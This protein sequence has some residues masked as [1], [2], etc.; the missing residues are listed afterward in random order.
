MKRTKLLGIKPCG[1]PENARDRMEV[2][3]TGRIVEVDGEKA[4]E[5]SMFYKGELKA[6]YFADEKVHYAYVGGK[7]NTCTLDN[8]ERLCKG[9]DVK[10]DAYWNVGGWKWASRE[11]EERAENFL[12]VWN[13]GAYERMLG[14]EKR[15][16]ARDRK[17]K[18]IE[19]EMA[20][21]PCVPDEV[22][23]WLES[24]IFPEHF[25]FFE[26]DGKRTTYNCTSCGCTGWKKI[27]WKRG[28]RTK[29]PKC[30]CEVRTNGRWAERTRTE[31]VVILQQYGQQWVE[32]QFKAVCKWGDGKKKINLYEKCRA[33]MEVG[34]CWGKVWY[35]L[36]SEADELEQDFWDANSRGQRF[37]NSYLWP[38]NLGEVLKCGNLEKSGMDILAD[39]GVKFNVNQF[40]TGFHNRPFVE[41]LIKTGLVRLAAEIVNDWAIGG[42]YVHGC[43]RTDAHDLRGTLQLDGNRVSRMKRMNG[44]ISALRW[45]QYE[46]KEGVRITQE[47]LDY[48]GS[49]DIDPEG[50]EEI[51]KG[52]KSVNRMVN[53]MKKQKVA[54]SKLIETWRDYLRMAEAEG[55]DVTDDIVRFPKD[56]KARHDQLVEIRNRRRDAERARKEEEK[57]AGLDQRIKKRLP[58]VA[59]Y[60][61][62]NDDYVVV[63]AARCKELVEEG[64]RLHHCV[65]ASDIY[66]ERMAEGKTW[67]L[68]LR[69]NV[70]L[71][72]PYYTIEID[73]KNDKI[74]QWYSE[75]DRKPDKEVVEKVL[76]KFSKSVKL[77]RKEEQAQAG[78]ERAR[79]QVPMAAMA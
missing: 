21:V 1:V 39:K 20:K 36:Y 9:E 52:L 79:V 63:P 48:L 68:F 37:T 54:T 56:L 67:I 53:Y 13:I 5:I 40:I 58:Q 19:E 22:G 50:C 74:L 32:R 75:Y 6:R 34:E 25:L 44:G 41:Y 70:E 60:Y 12:G 8:V 16:R 10:H 35:G 72:T 62:Q 14:G 69:K 38:G 47:S 29:C 42:H 55:M 33:V 15:E 26:K 76:K 57:Y 45:L 43:V 30:G 66:M 17:Q 71:E 49:K 7:W 23:E 11:D 51:L 18:R 28:K 3:A 64:R 61:W 73:M 31:Q 4:V 59:K 24:V 77:K 2:V 65:G 27:G 46:Q 78:Q